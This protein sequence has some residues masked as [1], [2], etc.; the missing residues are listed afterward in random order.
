MRKSFVMLAATGLV[1][2][3]VLGGTSAPARAAAFAAM[4]VVGDSL[5]DMGN[6]FDLTAALPLVPAVPTTPY[7]EGRFSNGPVYA[8]VLADRL[9]LTLDNSLDGGSN[10]A[11]GGAGTDFQAPQL[12]GLAPLSVEGQVAQFFAGRAAAGEPIAADELFVVFAGS[13]NLQQ[14]AENAGNADALVD[15]AVGDI[16][17]IVADLRAA[18]AET[19]LVP[20]APNLSRAPEFAGSTLAEQVTVQFNDGLS[21]LSGDGV[22]VFD[23]FA[24]IESAIADPARFGLAN[25]SDPCFTGGTFGIG[26]DDTRCAE[27][28]T[29][30]FWDELHP[31]AAAHAAL[32]EAMAAALMPPSPQVVPLPGSV[33]LFGSALAALALMY[34]VRR[35]S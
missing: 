15:N 13:N 29:Y 10:Y 1:A 11:F 34:S 4:T 8:E 2:G 23:T 16:G 6:V 7:L 21:A 26:D 30:L 9:G 27:P 35:Q 14:A 24:L 32:G 19:I 18:G 25:V 3:A 5:S 28:D 33:L 12:P 17:A 22:I 20:N 31:T